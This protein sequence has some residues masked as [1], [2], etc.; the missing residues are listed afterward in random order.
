MA[1]CI[2]VSCWKNCSGVKPVQQSQKDLHDKT[3]EG[4]LPT[5]LSVPPQGD[6]FTTG[7]LFL[8][9]C[10]ASFTHSLQ[11]AIQRLVFSGAPSESSVGQSPEIWKAFLY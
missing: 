2:F 6:R 4:C 9:L 7:V 8:S 10:C 1:Q 3:T 11:C 5:R